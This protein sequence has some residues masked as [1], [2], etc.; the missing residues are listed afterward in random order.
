M[1]F[2]IDYSFM[3]PE[4]ASDIIEADDSNQAEE[5][6]YEKFVEEEGLTFAT[7]EEIKMVNFQI[8]CVVE[9][10]QDKVVA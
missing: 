10:K 7:D 1:R 3:A 5:R 6:M 2:K 9:I 8:D 4:W